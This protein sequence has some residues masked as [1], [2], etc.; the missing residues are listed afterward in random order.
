MQGV[1][2]KL[3]VMSRD[4]DR[5]M[6]SMDTAAVSDIIEKFSAQF[7]DLGI[8]SQLTSDAMSMQV[9]GATPQDEVE[10]LVRECADEAGLEL[11]AA[12][13]SAANGTLQQQ[14][15]ASRAAVVDET[16]ALESRLAGL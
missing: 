6:S 13:P 15:L 14:P 10:A 9:A 16:A 12:M 1:T 11:G 8:Q 4:L 2:K 7:E 3:G 5:A